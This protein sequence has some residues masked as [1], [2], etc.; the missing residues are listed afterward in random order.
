MYIATY[1]LRRYITTYVVMY[2]STLGTYL[3]RYYVHTYIVNFRRYLRTEVQ[4]RLPIKP[5]KN[6]NCGYK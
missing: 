4:L 5:L 6:L 1:Y 3:R 2:I